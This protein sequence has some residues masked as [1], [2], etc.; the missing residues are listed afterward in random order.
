MTEAPQEPVQAKG[1]DERTL[2][3]VR[4]ILDLD[5][6]PVMTQLS[7][8]LSEG[9]P[10]MVLLDAC[11]QGM[12]A[13]GRRFEEK[14]YFIAAL[15]MAGEIMRRATELLEPHLPRQHSDPVKN[16]ILIGTVAGDIHDLGKNLFAILARCNGLHIVDLGVEVPPERF[17]E[18]AA[19]T[20]PDLIGL[21]CVLT[22]AIASLKATIE[23]LRR[24]LPTPRPPIIAGGTCVDEKIGLHVGADF[25]TQNAA[26]GLRYCLEHIHKKNN[27]S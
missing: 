1:E 5:E 25:S 27:P 7:A 20:R 14:R 12:Q 11:I 21:S 15:I 19:R 10:P 8:M 2:Q 23:L 9:Y 3:L 22:G 26:Q 13:V 4:L 17:L 16:T 6:G 18:E 24:R